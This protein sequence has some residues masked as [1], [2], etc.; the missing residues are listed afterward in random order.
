MALKKALSI[1]L[2][3]LL[4]PLYV[5]QV[6]AQSGWNAEI[7][8]IV[9]GLGDSVKIA[10][11]TVQFYDVSTNWSLVTIRISYP[12]GAQ[13]LF[14]REGEIGYF[15]S[16][17]SEVFEVAVNSIDRE[18]G[19]IVLSIASPLRKVRENLQM[20]SNETVVIN[21]NV[22]IHLVS[23]WEN[24][25]MLGVKLPPLENFKVFNLTAGQSRGLD[26]QLSPGMMYV[27][28]LRVELESATKDVAILNVYLPSLDAENLTLQEIPAGN[29][30]KPVTDEATVYVEAYRGYV[31]LNE[32]LKVE[33]PFG[34]AV[35]R[36]TTFSVSGGTN[37]PSTDFLFTVNFTAV[38]GS[39]ISREVKLPINSGPVDVGRIPIMLATYG[40]DLEHE[41]VMVGIF[42]P[43]G[44]MV[45]KPSEPAN[46]T[47]S[48]SVVP[49]RLMVGGE[50]A[51]YINVANNGPGKA[52][53][54]VVAA[55]VPNGFEL[56]GKDT[57]W[58]IGDLEPYSKIPAI[59]YILKPTTPGEFTISGV[60]A[61]Y[62]D[63]SGR[64]IQ[65][66]S[67]PDV[68]VRVYGVPE[69]HVTV[70]GSNSTFGGNW[71]TYVHTE[72][73]SPVTV[74]L[75][76]SA[77]GTNPNFEYVTDAT[78]HISYPRGVVGPALIGIGNIGAG[79][80]V[81]KALQIRVLETGRFPIKASLTYRDPLGGEHELD[82]G[83]VLVI[84]TIPPKVIVKKQVVHV[85]PSEKELPGFVNESLRNST[86]AGL[87]AKE[88]YGVLSPY[89]PKK[90]NY[91]KVSTIV[92]AVLVLVLGYLTYGYYREVQTFRRFLLRKRKSRPGGL[93]KKWKRDELEVLLRELRLEIVRE[94]LSTEEGRPPERRS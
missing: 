8:P 16:K 67:T 88:L 3:L 43:V 27:D 94:N 82:L 35:V 14:L 48:I 69:L 90:S 25:A 41:K 57:G 19:R 17:E 81:E 89:L 30:S 74:L 61:T 73:G 39:V 77:L 58:S 46:V 49:I 68:Y 31:P 20:V 83:T 59:V 40:A 53:D 63:E 87:L 4:V 79:K 76:V 64:K 44:S 34:T 52:S 71:N 85:Y 36:I 92:L 10:N 32:P 65:V 7:S 45:S 24:G 84:N 72:N 80:N 2:V 51:V 18:N 42:A 12:G 23:S 54:L 93:P 6:F 75:N 21:K 9:L 1:L 86:N 91:W 56:M 37:F 38:N 13:L 28:Y 5:P 50:V 22:V 78:L 15:P 55:P 47:I 29:G 66:R 70:L 11:Y 62:Y 33:T 60:M 26:Y